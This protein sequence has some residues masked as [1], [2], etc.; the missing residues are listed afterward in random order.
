MN[1]CSPQTGEL[2]HR[3]TV[4]QL[5]FNICHIVAILRLSPELSVSLFKKSGINW[6]VGYLDTLISCCYFRLSLFIVMFVTSLV[7]T[8]L[9]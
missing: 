5:K 1:F 8:C 4:F 7:L 9:V 6:A 3:F 2:S